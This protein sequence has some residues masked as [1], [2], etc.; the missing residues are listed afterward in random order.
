AR[1]EG[2]NGIFQAARAR[3]R[4]YRNDSTFITMIYLIAS[5]AGS[6]LKSP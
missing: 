2:L 6:I 5:P 1:L 3:A 4:G